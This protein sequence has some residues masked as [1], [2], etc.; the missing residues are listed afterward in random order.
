MILAKGRC[1]FVVEGNE[2]GLHILSNSISDA[3]SVIMKP[4]DTEEVKKVKC[5]ITP[6]LAMDSS[7]RLS[8][9][10]TVTRLSQLLTSL[11]G[12]VLFAVNTVWKPS[13]IYSEFVVFNN[14]YRVLI[15]FINIST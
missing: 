7:R 3:T 5:I 2:L 12:Q 8:I 13:V 11:G 9:H 10:D 15:T 4:A 6:M 1:M 14:M